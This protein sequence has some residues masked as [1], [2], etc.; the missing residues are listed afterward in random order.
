MSHRDQLS[1]EKWLEAIGTP[2]EAVSGS[3]TVIVDAERE[4]YAKWGLGVLS[5]GYVLS[6]AGLLGVWK[7]GKEKGIWNRPTVNGSR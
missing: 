4:I 7:I 2:G 6:L 3:A 1:T 5:W